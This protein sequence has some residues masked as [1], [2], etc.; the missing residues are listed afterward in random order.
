MIMNQNSSS[1]S[2][3]QAAEAAEKT[4]AIDKLSVIAEW[5]APIIAWAVVIVLCLAIAGFLLG[6][7]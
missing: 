4:R 3:L 7:E 1:Q 5:L 6:E 2:Q